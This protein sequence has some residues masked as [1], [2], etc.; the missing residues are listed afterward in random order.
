ME[1]NRMPAPMGP[2]RP[3]VHYKFIEA[4]QVQWFNRQ[5]YTTTTTVIA[6]MLMDFN[7]LKVLHAKVMKF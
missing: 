5:E 3:D 2:Y 7:M 1:K 6:E 4:G